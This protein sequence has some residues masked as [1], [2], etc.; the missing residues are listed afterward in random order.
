MKISTEPCP[1]SGRQL[2]GSALADSDRAQL[3]EAVGGLAAPPG[4]LDD[5]PDVVAAGG[6]D[7]AVQPQRA[8][9]GMGDRLGLMPVL[10]DPVRRPD[11]PEPATGG[12]EAGHE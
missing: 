9:L 6:Q 10:V 4:R 11:T 2:H 7:V 3:V 12:T 5:Q 1:A 8:R